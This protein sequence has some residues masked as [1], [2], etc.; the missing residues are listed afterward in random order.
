MQT[1]RKEKRTEDEKDDEDELRVTDVILSISGVRYPLVWCFGGLPGFDL[2]ARGSV[3]CHC[4]RTSAGTRRVEEV[5]ELLR[6]TRPPSLR[7]D[8]R[9]ALCTAPP[10]HGLPRCSRA[11]ASP[12]FIINANA[13]YPKLLGTRRA[14][15]DGFFFVAHLQSPQLHKVSERA[16]RASLV[17]TSTPTPHHRWYL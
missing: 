9:C 8:F 15:A 4:C 7:V 17:Q 5:W 6:L 3:F 1:A 2:L 14:K 13:N 16:E 12:T 11:I 10:P